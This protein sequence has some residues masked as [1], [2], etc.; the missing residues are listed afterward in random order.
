MLEPFEV[1]HMENVAVLLGR[2]G[3]KWFP[4]SDVEM[5]VGLKLFLPVSPFEEPH[6][7]YRDKG[8]GITTTGESFGGDMLRR[9]V[10]GYLEG[11]F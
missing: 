10:T 7:R 6:F 5:E 3:Y 11:S 9:M 4:A 8:G 1:D 2:I